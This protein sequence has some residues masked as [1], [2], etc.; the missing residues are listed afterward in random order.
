[1]IPGG[2]EDPRDARDSAA[3]HEGGE[4]SAST[5]NAREPRGIGIRPNRVELA[6]R[7]ER[8]EVIGADGDDTRDDDGEDRD[9]GHRPPRD[10]EERVRQ[11]AGD[12]LSSSNDERVDATNDVEHREGHDQARHAPDD[13]EKSVHQSTGDT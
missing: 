4:Y 6:A 12:N 5:R 13:G 2:V 9:P 10:L 8:A 1:S 11:R 3:D 7:A